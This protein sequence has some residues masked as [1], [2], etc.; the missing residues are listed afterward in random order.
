MAAISFSSCTKDEIPTSIPPL[1]LSI[2]TSVSKSWQL[3]L[4]YDSTG[5]DITGNYLSS[6]TSS[7]DL[8]IEK[9]GTANIITY[10]DTSTTT[11]NGTWGVSNDFKEIYLDF[12][13]TKFSSMNLKLDDIELW[14]KDTGNNE[15]HFK[16]KN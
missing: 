5:N 3:D 11:Q 14:L 10:N 9:D 7:K 4:V 12:G 1:E 15:Y 13:S 16:L 6:N 2:G 8:N